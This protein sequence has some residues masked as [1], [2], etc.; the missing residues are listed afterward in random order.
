M[1][2]P[3]L[4][5]V[6]A[7]AACDPQPDWMPETAGAARDG[8]VATAQQALS[9]GG[10]FPDSMLYLKFRINYVLN[11]D[12]AISTGYWSGVSPPS[13][14]HVVPGFGSDLQCPR[15]WV[16]MRDSLGLYPATSWP[17]VGASRRTYVTGGWSSPINGQP[18]QQLGSCDYEI[19]SGGYSCHDPG[20]LGN[21]QPLTNPPNPN[22]GACASG[23]WF[24]AGGNNMYDIHIGL[25]CDSWGGYR[26][27]GHTDIAS[28]LHFP[29]PWRNTQYVADFGATSGPYGNKDFWTQATNGCNSGP[30]VPGYRDY[31]PIQTCIS[32]ILVGAGTCIK[33]S[34]TGFGW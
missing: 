33:W 24:P 17:A 6:L 22:A 28:W 9:G 21:G 10:V 13:D 1:K 3:A 27:G 29:T 15:I 25:S 8:G 2:I 20:I 16:Y 7:L 11:Y 34:A 5:A 19:H 23:E 31:G 30:R 12:D 4:L 18:W 32:R 14:L 26:P